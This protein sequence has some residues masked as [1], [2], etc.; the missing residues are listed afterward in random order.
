MSLPKANP[1]LLPSQ[2]MYHSPNLDAR[3]TLSVRITLTS[4][5]TPR[6]FLLSSSYHLFKVLPS[7]T[8][9]ASNNDFPPQP[10]PRAPCA[11]RGEGKVRR[12]P[13]GTPLTTTSLRES[14]PAF[15]RAASASPAFR[16]SVQSTHQGPSPQL[17]LR[18]SREPCVQR[19]RHAQRPTCSDANFQSSRGTS[20]PEP[21]GSTTC[22]SRYPAKSLAPLQKEP[23]PF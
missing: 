7:P 23:L 15:R 18:A 8:H 5:Q 22:R 13:G 17:A 16:T 6:G 12:G 1:P 2:K 19:T 20:A 3:P 21:I 4:N 11:W 10:G 14:P 9:P